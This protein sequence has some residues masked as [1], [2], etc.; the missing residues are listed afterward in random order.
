MFT[1]NPLPPFALSRL[2]DFYR[3][4]YSVSEMMEDRL[5]TIIFIISKSLTLEV[6]N[7]E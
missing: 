5:Q 4:C 3:Y 1:Q 6:S 7:G 2:S